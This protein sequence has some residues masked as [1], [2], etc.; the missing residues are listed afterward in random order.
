MTDVNEATPP[1]V[2]RRGRSPAFWSWKIIAILL[3]TIAAVAGG[4]GY[5]YF[6]SRPAPQVADDPVPEPPF[7]LE[8]KPFV[9]SIANDTGSPHFVQLG[10]NLALSGKAAGAAVTVMLPEIQDA[11]RQTAL[12]F[13][14]EDIV[15]PAGVDKLRQAMIA[16]A[17]RLLL[18]QL[19]ADGVKQLTGGKRNGGVVQHLYFSTLIVE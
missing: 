15:T 5:W 10:V 9:V 1:G 14:V 16:T 3:L 17:N 19:G 13:K 8:I 18:Q 6:A 2:K 11:L 4:V 7:Y 12:G